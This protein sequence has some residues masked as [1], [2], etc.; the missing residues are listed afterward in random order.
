MDIPS[1]IYSFMLLL[2]SGQFLIHEINEVGVETY[3]VDVETLSLTPNKRFILLIE[4][5]KVTQQLQV[6]L[7]EAECQNPH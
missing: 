7:T 6:P 5:Q 2:G 1:I 4:N 3:Q